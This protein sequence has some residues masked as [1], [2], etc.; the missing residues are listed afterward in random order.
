MA[1]HKTEAPDQFVLVI[2]SIDHHHSDSYAIP[3][4]ETALIEKLAGFHMKEIDYFKSH[5][6]Q[7][8]GTMIEL[9]ASLDRFAIS[10]LAFPILVARIINISMPMT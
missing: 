2:L 5:H 3:S 4:N 1:E 6:T 10:T 7:E 9:L 8:E